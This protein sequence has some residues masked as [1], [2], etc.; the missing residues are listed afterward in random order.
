MSFGDK[1]SWVL[2]APENVLTSDYAGRDARQGR[3]ARSARPARACARHHRWRVRG[4]SRRHTPRSHCGRTR[5]PRGHRPQRRCR[6]AEVLRGSR[7]DRESDQRRQQRDRRCS[8]TPCRARRMGRQRRREQDARRRHRGVRRCGRRQHGVRSGD[9]TSEAGNG[10]GVAIARTHGGDDRRRRQRRAGIEGRQLRCRDGIGQRGIP[11]RRPTRADGLELLGDAGG[12]RRRPKSD[13]QHRA[14][15]QL[16]PRQDHVLSGALGAHRHL[17]A[18]L[19]VAPDPP[20]DPQ[21]VHHRTACVRP[22]P[23]TQRSTRQRGLPPPCARPGDP[24]RRRDRHCHDERLR[25]RPDRRLHRCGSRTFGRGVGR[26][27]RGA[28][29]PVPRRSSAEPAPRRIGD[30]HGRRVRVGVPDAMEP[31]AVRATRH[32]TMGVCND[33]RVH[34][35]SHGRCWNW[36]VG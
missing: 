9:S 29:E 6:D 11:R 4:R 30:H 15:R 27:F 32:R 24:R 26:R 14:G 13:Q 28:D 10:R 16:V 36:E 25:D 20:V 34:R 3:S 31:R 21:L 19:S 1:G 8:G 33:G 35:A 12:R 23:R 22:R 2:G 18:R 17:R 7:R 5:A